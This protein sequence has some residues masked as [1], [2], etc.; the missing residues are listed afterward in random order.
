MGAFEWNLAANSFPGYGPW[1]W[2]D[3][4]NEGGICGLS[5]SFPDGSVVSIC[6]PMQETLEMWV[7]SW[8]G[9]SPWRR[10]WQ[11]ISV[12][13]PG[14]FHEQRSLAGC[15]PW[16][17]QVV[18]HDW[19]CMHTHVSYYGSINH[20]HVLLVLLFFQAPSL[21]NPFV[22]SP[23][24][25]PSHSGWD[26]SSQWV[27]IIGPQELEPYPPPYTSLYFLS[28]NPISQHVCAPV[29]ST[30]GGWGVCRQP[31]TRAITCSGSCSRAA[32]F[33]VWSTLPCAW[34]MKDPSLCRPP[35]WITAPRLRSCTASER[36][37]TKSWCFMAEF[38]V[39]NIS[40]SKWQ[41]E[42]IAHETH[43]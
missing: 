28:Q 22:L 30:G 20:G 23:I 26:V 29:G 42:R 14:K 11:P 1:H 35:Q 41:H 4:S 40:L 25:Y 15:S 8:V 13:L 5:Q 6:L 9:K 10:A 39:V 37:R 21:K 17:S 7:W 19:A 32:C 24:V 33:A 43:I 3:L 38:L 31:V 16:G 36:A 27:S 12:F 34:L 18:G 2:T